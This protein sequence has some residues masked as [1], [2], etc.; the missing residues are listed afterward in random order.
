M[1][2]RLRRRDARDVRGGATSRWRPPPRR[3]ATC[4]R[5]RHRRAA[6]PA[7]R[8]TSTDGPGASA[9][10][11]SSARSS[12]R[13]KRKYASPLGS[14]SRGRGG[15]SADD[16]TGARPTRGSIRRRS[17]CGRGRSDAPSASKVADRGLRRDAGPCGERL[18]RRRAE[19]VQVAAGELE[20]RLGRADAGRR[21]HPDGRLLR[22]VPP[23]SHP[24]RERGVAQ[25]VRR[26]AERAR[27]GAL[28][29]CAC[30]RAAPPAG[31]PATRRRAASSPIPAAGRG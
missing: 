21:R 14:E 6:R 31:R 28:R 22:A 25:P 5:W 2:P 7:T 11:T 27:R 9:F 29:S 13:W 17:A 10:S 12:G 3:G 24:A 23:D 16:G 8:A 26:L 19:D 1:R 4:R 20:P 18:R 15:A 30:R